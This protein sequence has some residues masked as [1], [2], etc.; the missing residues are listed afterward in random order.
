M[1]SSYFMP[2]EK[3][4]DQSKPDARRRPRDHG[5]LSVKV[6]PIVVHDSCSFSNKIS[7]IPAGG[8]PTHLFSFLK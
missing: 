8:S 4:L 6:F 5:G 1:K 3:L 7:I 2:L